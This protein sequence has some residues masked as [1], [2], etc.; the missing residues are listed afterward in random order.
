MAELQGL[1]LR[2]VLLARDP[3]CLFL[4]EVARRTG[5]VYFGPEHEFQELWPLFQGARFSV[6]GH[7]H[8]VIFG[9]MVG[10]PFIPLS[11]NNHKMQGVCEL[12]QWHRVDPF[13]ITWLNSCRKEIVAEA[14]Y[15]ETERDRLSVRLRERTAL[16]RVEARK[17]GERI[18]DVAAPIAG[19]S[20]P[21]RL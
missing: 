5:A 12:L 21:E 4:E 18:G 17:L 9:A 15:L 6:T 3:H 11:T 13:D 16:L 19:N 10:C 2:G 14:R 1:G 8:Y 20:P 7:F